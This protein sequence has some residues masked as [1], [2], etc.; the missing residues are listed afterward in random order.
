MGILAK[1]I[2]GRSDAVETL[3]AFEAYCG[4]LIDAAQG[5]TDR[6]WKPEDWRKAPW[7]WKPCPRV[8]R[9]IAAVAAI[10]RKF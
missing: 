2:D 1:L 3:D 9:R 8:L 6:R 5:N 10:K 4:A 7:Y